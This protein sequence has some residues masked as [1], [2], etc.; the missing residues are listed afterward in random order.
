MNDYSITPVNSKFTVISDGLQNANLTAAASAAGETSLVLTPE[1]VSDVIRHHQGIDLQMQEQLNK[2]RSILSRLHPSEL[3]KVIEEARSQLF[4]QSANQMLRI[5]EALHQTKLRQ[6]NAMCTANTKAVETMM[7]AYLTATQAAAYNALLNKMSEI[8]AETDQCIIR[9]CKSIENIPVPQLKEMRMRAL[10]DTMQQTCDIYTSL[11]NRF[12][13]TLNAKDINV[14]N[15]ML[16][17]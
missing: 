8:R 12:I 16:D 6:L 9:D 2:R 3:D 5:N 1:Q 7:S 17:Q 15:N 14:P 4:K 10:E 11:I 13:S